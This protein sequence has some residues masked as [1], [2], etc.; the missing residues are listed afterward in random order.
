MTIGAVAALILFAAYV[1]SRIA[2][3][4]LPSFQQLA[5]RRGTVWSARFAPDG[6][7]IIYGASWEGRPSETFLT[8][9]ESTE[10]R[11][12]GLSDAS[13]LAISSTGEMAVLLKPRFIGYPI[14]GTLARVPLAG[15]APREVADNVLY[16]DWSPDGK[17]LA[18]VRGVGGKWRLEYPIGKVLY[19]T[20][21]WISYPRISPTG[22]EVAFFDQ[23]VRYDN[24][25]SVTV[26]DREGKKK[27]LVSGAAGLFGLAWS[28]DEIWFCGSLDEG[29]ALFATTAAGSRREVM[30][31]PG[32]TVLHDISRDGRVLIA[33]ES[34]RVGIIGLPPGE[35]K[36]R[37]LSWL[38][39]SFARDMS[40]DGK[41]LLFDEEAESAGLTGAVYLRKTDGS[42]AVRLGEGYAISLSPDGKWVLASLRHVT[43]L[44]LVLL[45]TGVGEPKPLLNGSIVPR[46][47]GAWLPDGGRV[48]FVGNSPGHDAQ[49]FVQDIA[50]GQ[51]RAITP[52]G[53]TV[54]GLTS[55]EG[56]AASWITPDGK[57]VIAGKK[58]MTLSLYPIDG[59]EALPIPGLEIGD[60]P[61]RWTPD[62]RSLYLFR[63]E[64][65]PAKVY[66]L[67]L[68][69]GRKELWKELVPNDPAGISIVYT[70]QMTPDAKSYVYSYARDLSDLYL[71]GGLK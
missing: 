57:Y 40:A 37:D 52:E 56:M 38:D 53:V 41:T 36:E 63:L 34:V 13:I 18:V 45:P 59:G 24:R 4:P 50:G 17:D 2:S 42:A 70:I 67:E 10:A 31:F 62:G 15:G 47:V 49:C 43:P 69:T 29:T 26:V 35:T 44:Q 28:G 60:V 22:N 46:E 25:G 30:R 9:P 23:P 65:V 54:G 32:L 27:S 16:A 64:E 58:E 33:R 7:T 8:R 68:S 48:L 20:D 19:E 5:F 1:G 11:T 6:H 61:I 51:P 55:P 21:A 39:G 71:V 3:R 14:M 66:R 12:L